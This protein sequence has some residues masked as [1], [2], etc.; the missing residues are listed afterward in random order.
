MEQKESPSLVEKGCPAHH[1]LE[2]VQ[3]SLKK[4]EVVATLGKCFPVLQAAGI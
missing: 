1:P 4:G 2:V 3:I